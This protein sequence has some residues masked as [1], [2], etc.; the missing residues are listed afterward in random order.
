[1][2]PVCPVPRNPPSR[3]RM[4]GEEALAVDLERQRAWARGWQETG[5]ALEAFRRSALRALT[6]QKALR[7]TDNLLA[8]GAEMPLSAERRGTSGLVDQQR[9]LARLRP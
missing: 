6:P 2:T 9:L 8:L 4:S 3:G 1:V 5:R 7:A